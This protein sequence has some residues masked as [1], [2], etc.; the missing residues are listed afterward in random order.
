MD[1][2]CDGQCS[3]VGAGQITTFDGRDYDFLQPNARY[4]VTQDIQLQKYKV[5]I[6]HEY[7]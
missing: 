3:I 6:H 1:V 7:S 2:D 5:G 4:V